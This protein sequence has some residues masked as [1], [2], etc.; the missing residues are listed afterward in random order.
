M[1]VAIPISLEGYRATM[2]Y[3]MILFSESG[4]INECRSTQDPGPPTTSHLRSIEILNFLKIT[5]LLQLA[6]NR[7]YQDSNGYPLY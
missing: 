5:I 1:L 3:K 4:T 7:I 6:I 2:I